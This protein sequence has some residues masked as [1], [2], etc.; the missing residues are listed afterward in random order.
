MEVVALQPHIERE[1]EC[2]LLSTPASLLYYNLKY[3]DFLKDLLGC[4]GEYLIAISNKQIRGVL[5]LLFISGERGRV[6]NSLPFYGSNGGILTDDRCAYDALLAAYN[7]IARDKRTISATY[8]TNPFLENGSSKIHH[9]Y[10]DFRIAQFTDIAFQNDYRVDLLSRIES[11]ARRNVKKAERA[12]V[13]VEIDEGQLKR[14]EEMHRE[15]IIAIGG[16]P[17]SH[18]FFALIPKHF[19]PGEDY[20]LYV[21]KKG[22]RIIAALLV[23]YFNQTVEYFTP[24]T[25]VAYRS[26]EPSSLILV[27]AMT[28]A[29]RR[30]FNRW[31]WGGTWGTQT[32][33]HQF[34]KKWG[35]IERRYDYYTQ[36][37]DYSILNLTRGEVVKSFPNFFVVPF[38]ALKTEGENHGK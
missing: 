25:D 13:M 35:A 36:L 1:Y 26:L 6:Y 15:N 2:Y 18:D 33:V 16:L 19:A 24:A 28:D 14:L 12:G 21:A 22:T 4:E 34:K 5:P 29:A 8:I 7:K 37:N 17:K 3:R 38:T 32:G 31:N 23:F 20:N 30:G 9:N 11:S 10:K 27:T